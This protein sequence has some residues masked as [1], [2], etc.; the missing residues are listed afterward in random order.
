M[1]VHSQRHGKYGKSTQANINVESNV[2]YDAFEDVYV[3][4]EF[5][6]PDPAINAVSLEQY[7]EDNIRP[8]GRLESRLPI[9]SRE[10]LKCMYPEWLDDICAFKI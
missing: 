8:N 9:S 7:D 2:H 3:L 10:Q 5:K 1:P 4:G 6:N